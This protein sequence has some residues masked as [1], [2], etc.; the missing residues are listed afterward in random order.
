LIFSYSLPANS[1]A[2]LK[3]QNIM[4]LAIFSLLLA[5]AAAF[6]T[7]T[8]RPTFGSSTSLQMSKKIA[9]KLKYVNAI[10]VADLPS[11]GNAVSAVAGGLAVCIV[12]D[13]KGTLYALGDKCPPINQPLSFGTVGTGY[14][15]DPVL[16]TKFNLKTGAVDE[17][18]PS[19]IG[20]LIG[21][22]FDP[23]GVPSYSVK[24]AGAFVQVQVDINAKFAFE[25]EYWTGVLDAQGKSDGKYY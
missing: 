2:R 16:G 3:N 20:K 6:S 11:P 9:Q 15:S 13:T 18:C 21:A 7:R 4:Q 10:A 25:A 19:G 23:V 5:G 12:V 1:I 24:K 17:W 22:V 14:I 8:N